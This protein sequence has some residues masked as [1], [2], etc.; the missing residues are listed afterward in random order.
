M[1]Q[2]GLIAVSQFRGIDYGA[3]IYGGD[4]VSG[5]VGIIGPGILVV[6]YVVHYVNL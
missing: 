2:A 3:I 6:T 5:I 1:E 4:D